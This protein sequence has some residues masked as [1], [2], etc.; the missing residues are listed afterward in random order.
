MDF[1]K[2]NHFL[3]E[4]LLNHDAFSFIQLIK[5]FACVFMRDIDLRCPCLPLYLGNADLLQ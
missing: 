4:T 2:L 1:Q 5:S 3:G